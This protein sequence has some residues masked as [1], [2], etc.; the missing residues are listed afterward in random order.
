MMCVSYLL[1][2]FLRSKAGGQA[3]GVRS[4]HLA[5]M[6]GVSPVKNNSMPTF[7][8][9]MHRFLHKPRHRYSIEGARQCRH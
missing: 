3:R 9:F 4:S 5:K 7:T 6:R 8:R 2:K 1:R